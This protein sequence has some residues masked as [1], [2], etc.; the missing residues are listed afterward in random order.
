[1]PDLIFIPAKKNSSRIKNKNYKKLKGKPLI[2]FTLK[3][4]KIFKK[5]YPV[6]I[7]SDSKKI[8][9]YSKKKFNF[10]SPYLRPR[11][12]SKKNSR[13]EDAIIHGVKWYEKY[14]KTKI[15]NII[16]MQPTSPLRRVSVIHKII[17]F[18]KKKK[19]ESLAT[20][21]HQKDNLIH[22]IRI[23]FKDYKN[24]QSVVAKKKSKKKYY[25][26]N[27][28]LFIFSYKFLKKYNKVIIKNKTYLYRTNKIE[29]IDIDFLDDFT[30][31]G[32]LI[33]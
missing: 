27:G 5:N 9:N 12:L 33:K 7:S 2:Y 4:C 13:I 1:M 32:S 28:Y 31:A 30:I 25:Y 11:F 6:F 15:N 24:W 18:Y 8:L 20:I 23:N 16:L 21:T 14:Y 19:L 10:Y 29:S 17:N 22:H 26:F 3:I